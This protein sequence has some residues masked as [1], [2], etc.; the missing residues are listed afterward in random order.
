MKTSQNS[1]KLS[2]KKSTVST[3]D[4]QVDGFGRTSVVSNFGRTSVV[5]NF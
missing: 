5:S 3:F 4:V 1:Q 2:I